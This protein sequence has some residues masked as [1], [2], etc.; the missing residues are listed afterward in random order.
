LSRRRSRRRLPRM[1]EQPQ[2]DRCRI[3]VWWIATS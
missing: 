2:T 3:D 1:P